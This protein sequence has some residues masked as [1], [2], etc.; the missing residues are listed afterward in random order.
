MADPGLEN[1]KDKEEARASEIR[2]KK[3][4]AEEAKRMTIDDLTKGFINYVKMGLKLEKAD[5]QKLR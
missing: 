5:G 1:E 2:Q 4:F 3:K